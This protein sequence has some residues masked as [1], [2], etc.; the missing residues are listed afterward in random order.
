MRVGESVYCSVCQLRKAPRGRAVPDV[1]ANGMCGR[2]C[3]GYGTPPHPG[4][5][6]PGE[7]EEEF[8]FPCSVPA[9]YRIQPCGHP[10][11]EIVSSDEGTHY[12]AA[13]ERD[14]RP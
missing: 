10:A 14:A 2:D 1:M 8:G 9:D 7:T 13:C 12:C 6:W 11:T 5:L 4:D 3:P